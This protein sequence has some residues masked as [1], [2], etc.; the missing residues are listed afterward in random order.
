MEERKEL[1]QFRENLI[2]FYKKQEYLIEPVFR[3]ALA[4]SVLFFLRAHLG[5]HGPEGAALGSTMLN[6]I[7]ALV[8]T[9]LPASACAGIL[10]L[11]MVWDMY[12]LSLEATAVCAALILL[13]ILLYFRFS[14]EDVV[15]LI[16]MPAACQIN[17][18]YAVAVLAGL[19]FGPGAA[20][21]VVFGLLFTKYVLLVEGGL[22]ESSEAGQEALHAGEQM[23]DNFR[24]LIDG[25]V[26]DRPMIILAAALALTVMIV[27]FVRH[28]MIEHAWTAAIAAGCVTELAVLLAGDM[29]FNTNIDLTEVIIGVA[30]AFVLGQ[31]VRFFVFNVDFLRIENVQFEDE[32]YYY[33]VR[34][35][36]K[37]MVPVPVPDPEQFS[38]PEEG[39]A[40]RE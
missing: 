14:P 17:L 29:L 3:F 39:G 11:V 34:A 32:D 15:L 18:Q 2:Q 36:P 10:A 19:L 16:L 6:V 40:E 9:L 8:C 24:S 30:A 21:P 7:L 1:Y 31:I 38:R 37:T 22:P 23:I 27:C 13:C 28:L 26:K 25:M 35:V 20:V 5:S 33:Y 4:L 12:S